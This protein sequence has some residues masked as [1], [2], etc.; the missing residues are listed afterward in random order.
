MHEAPA[1]TTETYGH[2]SGISNFG[3]HGLGANGAGVWKA[4]GGHIPPLDLEAL[5]MLSWC[6]EGT[7]GR[8]RKL[9]SHNETRDTTSTLVRMA[10]N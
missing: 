1:A 9:C 7:G 10:S 3:A 8:H 4:V 6:G 2:F 5:A